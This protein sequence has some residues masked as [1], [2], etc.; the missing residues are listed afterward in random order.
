MMAA[1]LNTSI[2]DS[3]IW[4]KTLSQTNSFSLNLMMSD[5]LNSAI[6]DS[7]N[8]YKKLHSF[9]LTQ[10]YDGSHL[11]FYH[12]WFNYFSTT[13][14]RSYILTHLDDGSN[15]E[16]CHVGFSHCHLGFRY[17]VIFFQIHSKTPSLH[18][19]SDSNQ[20]N[21]IN[22]MM[23]AILKFCHLGFRHF[24]QNSNSN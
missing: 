9:I 4:H 11:E 5:I 21:L 20:F 22:L 1:I 17:L 15:L 18:S 6:L 10:L 14:L 12:L 2:L 19:E 3:E 7:A 8:L 13:T 16:F 24:A 23:S